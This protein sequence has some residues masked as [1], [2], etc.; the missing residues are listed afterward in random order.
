MAR[1]A[2]SGLVLLIRGEVLR[3]YPGTIILAVRADTL[4]QGE[5]DEIY[6]IFR[7]TLE[8]DIAFIGFELTEARARGDD[9]Q[10]GYYFVLQEPP[11]E[12]RF[13][14][15]VPDQFGGDFSSWSQLTWGH[16]VTDAGAFDRLTHLPVA[17]PLHG[18]RLEEAEWGLNGAHMAHITLQRRVR[19]AIHAND[20]LP[21]RG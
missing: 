2:G 8:P 5:P 7:G 6:P 16:V 20:L 14:L 19:V 1:G 10:S 12:P 11:A 15:D 21:A 9:G 17:G 13:G 18:R 3:R 4:S